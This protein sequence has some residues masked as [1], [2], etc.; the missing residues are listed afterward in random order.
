MGVS[1]Q[2]TPSNMPI[3]NLKPELHDINAQ[4][5]GKSIDVY[6]CYHLEMK[7]GRI[8]GRRMDRHTDVQHET[9]IPHNHCVA[10]YKNLFVGTQK[11]FFV[12]ALPIRIY[13]MF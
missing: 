12:E 6:S 3:S 1:L 2:I 10:G 9:I 8:D 5:E 13:I 7:D 4:V 11:K